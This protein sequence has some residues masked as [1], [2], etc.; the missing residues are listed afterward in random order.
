M[1]KAMDVSNALRVASIFEQ[2]DV[3]SVPAMACR[4][5]AKYAK[6]LEAQLAEKGDVADPLQE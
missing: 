3:I 5:L 1:S 6:E 4:I 2:D